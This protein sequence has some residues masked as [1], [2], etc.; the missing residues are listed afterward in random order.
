MDKTEDDRTES[1]NMEY[2]KFFRERALTQEESKS[3]SKVIR[4]AGVNLAEFTYRTILEEIRKIQME[5]FHK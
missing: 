3:V 4:F 2:S 5:D 1:D